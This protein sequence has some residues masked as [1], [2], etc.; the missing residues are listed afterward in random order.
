MKP[1]QKIT[2]YRIVPAQFNYAKTQTRQSGSIGHL[3]S[4]GFGATSQRSRIK[5]A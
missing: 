2:S 5:F 3:P 4:P 1:H